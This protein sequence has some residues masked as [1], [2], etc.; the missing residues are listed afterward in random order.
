[1]RLLTAI[2]LAGTLG[3]SI[4]QVRGEPIRIG[5]QAGLTMAWLSTG[6]GLLLGGSAGLLAC[7]P[8]A[9]DRLFLDPGLM[10]SMKG[11]GWSA[12]EGGEDQHYDY[13]ELPLVLRYGL[14]AHLVAGLGVN[15]ALLVHAW[16]VSRGGVSDTRAKP[17]NFG[18]VGILGAEFPPFRVEARLDLGLLAAERIDSASPPASKTRAVSFLVGWLR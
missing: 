14:P 8:L 16:Q 15:P 6:N 1:M 7:I 12:G 18:V 2:L 13:L 11:G 4:A 10:F 9:R 3:T 5:A 17:F